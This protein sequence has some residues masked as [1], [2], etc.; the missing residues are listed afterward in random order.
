MSPA[1]TARPLAAILGAL[2]TIG[3]V[4]AQPARRATAFDRLAQLEREFTQTFLHEQAVAA[5]WALDNDVPLR[6][7]FSDGRITELVSVSGDGP[8]VK[9]TFNEVAAQSVS[10]DALWPGGSAGL[11]LNGS[12]VVLYEWDGGEVR[13]SHVELFGAV[14]WADDTSPGLSNHSTHVAG[15]MV[16]IG[17]Y[18]SSR[19][20]AFA[21]SVQAY[22]W[23]NDTAEMAA[24]GAAGALISNH[25]YGWIRGWYFDGLYWR[26]YG[27][28]SISE[29]ED[30]HFGFYDSSAQAWDQVAY[31]APYYLICKSAGNDRNDT[32][33]GGHYAIY[34]GWVWSTQ[35][36]DGDGGALG[37]D[38]IGQQGCAKNILTVGA[39]HD[40]TSGYAS[41][42]G[43]AVTSFTGWGPTDDGRIKPDIVANGIGLL[44]T[45]AT[46]DVSYASYSGTSMAS[47]SAAASLGLLVQHYR[48]THGGTDMRAATLKGLVIYTADECGA[49]DGPDYQFG[50]GLLNARAAAEHIT[51]DASNNA[52]IQQL[53]LSQGQTIRQTMISDG[54]TPIKALIIWT[55]P[56]GTPGPA[57]LDPPTPM[58][59]NDLDLR[60]I[61]PGN[62][63]YE[64]W[65]LDPATPAAPATRGDNMRDNVE[66]VVI[67]APVPGVYRLEIT[68]KGTLYNGSQDFALI[69]SD[70]FTPVPLR[71]DLAVSFAGYG[72]WIYDDDT[73]TFTN[74]HSADA[75]LLAA[76]DFDGDGS[77]EL[78]VTFTGYGT[79][80]YDDDT[81]T[82]TN[83]HSADAD[84]LAAGD[85]DGDGI[86][87]L[88]V[89]FAGY[90]TW[91]YDNDTGT[92]TNVHGADAALLAAGDF[93]GD[94]TDELAVSFAGFGT[95]IY[96][97]DT[98]TF[99]YVHS[100]DADLLAA[101]DFDGDG[102]DELAVSFAG[103]GTWIY[104]DDTGMYTY[105][106]SADAAVLAAGD[107]DGDGSDELAVS[108]VGYGTWI[109]DDD[110]ATFSNIDSEDAALMAA[111]DLDGDGR[112]ELAV[113]FAGFG[114]W[115][116]DD[117][118]ATFTN[119]HG[120][121]AAVLAVGD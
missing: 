105:I 106:H 65:V 80:I 49:A 73:G 82:F 62:T 25:S 6:E 96:D 97:D 31:N 83:I 72:T 84:L 47:P 43:V 79:W 26:W 52:A 55:D 87:E 109:Y 99:T 1:T 23:L 24:A 51:L 61:G 89:T 104:D 28:P 78:A 21:A 69:T 5:Q 102:T 74:I 7:V 113:S 41:P 48:A 22:D 12:G 2:L 100:A 14:T 46:S 11:N 29:T 58:L 91:I 15:T 111:G 75:A 20:M 85:F 107:F 42:A 19:G 44:S 112:D 13:G 117:D 40:V 71:K 114:T 101:G 35:A 92:Y 56:P 121:E 68:H 110:T 64:P 70:P 63:V 103:Y 66:L 95:W 67:V 33:V 115:I 88:A 81:G 116:Y 60:I 36:R 8:A 54:L 9:T 119:I 32:H 53:S 98:G 16:A 3:P 27:T 17:A 4:A 50:W 57:S 77:D 18:P 118:T 86:D 30:W 34:G 120:A 108:F 37:Y 93:D 10:A 38:T 94:G 90:G 45:V 59:V 39:V 76:G